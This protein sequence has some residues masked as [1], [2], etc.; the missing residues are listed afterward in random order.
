MVQENEVIMLILGIGVLIFTLVYRKAIKRIPAWQ[1]LISG[2]YML[3]VA[4][5]STVLEGF[6]W[7]VPLNYVEHLSYA[8]SSTLLAVWCWMLLYGRN[9]EIT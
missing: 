9:K 1:T 8:C 4:W 7:E 2:F 6:F 5:I 3:I